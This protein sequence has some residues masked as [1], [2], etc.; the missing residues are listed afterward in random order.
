MECG[1]GG[2]GRW[3]AQLVQL[4]LKCLQAQMRRQLFLQSEFS[5]MEQNFE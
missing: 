2:N 3:F 1:G 4:L 5:T